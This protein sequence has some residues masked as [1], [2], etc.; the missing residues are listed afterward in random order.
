MIAIRSAINRARVRAVANQPPPARA[1]THLDGRRGAA[2]VHV[3]PYAGS[4]V[5]PPTECRK[6]AG[7]VGFGAQLAQ[8]WITRFEALALAP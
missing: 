5:G 3:S 4:K 6:L 7:L 8:R 2:A 1:A